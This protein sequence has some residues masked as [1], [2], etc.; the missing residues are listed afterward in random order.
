VGV[1]LQNGY[2]VHAGSKGVAIVKLH[3]P[4]MY[5]YF[6][7]CGSVSNTPDTSAGK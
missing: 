3:D 1:Y 5:K 7:R 6:T 2:Y 4:Y